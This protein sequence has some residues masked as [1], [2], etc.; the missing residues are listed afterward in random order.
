MTATEAPIDR[1]TMFAG[2]GLICTPG[3]GTSWSY[4]TGRSTMH[5]VSLEEQGNL[6]ISELLEFEPD[7]FFMC[8]DCF[9]KVIADGFIIINLDL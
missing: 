9:T 8:D 2:A 4:F 7:P 5:A 3:C 6:F 1:N